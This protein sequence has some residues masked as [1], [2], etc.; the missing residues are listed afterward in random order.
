MLLDIYDPKASTW[1]QIGKRDIQTRKDWADVDDS[2]TERIS[3]RKKEIFKEIQGSN[4]LI[5]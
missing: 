5:G 3:K 4:P 2:I 1:L